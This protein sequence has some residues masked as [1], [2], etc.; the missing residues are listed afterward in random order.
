MDV[1]FYVSE[2]EKR[3]QGTAL[4]L[5]IQLLSGLVLSRSEVPESAVLPLDDLPSGIIKNRLQSLIRQRL[6]F[7]WLQQLEEEAKSA[8]T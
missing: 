7:H 8:D 2:K 1:S 5:S 6:L 4:V 3:R